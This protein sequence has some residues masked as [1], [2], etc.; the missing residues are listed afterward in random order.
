[1]VRHTKLFGNTITAELTN[2]RPT[3]TRTYERK[4][5]LH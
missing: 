4:Y 5:Y 3:N 1:V 2:F